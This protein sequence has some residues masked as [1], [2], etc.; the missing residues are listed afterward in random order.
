[1]SNSSEG[2]GVEGAIGGLILLIMILSAVAG[3]VIFLLELAI[4]IFLASIVALFFGGIVI[5]VLRKQRPLKQMGIFAPNSEVRQINFLEVFTDLNILPILLVPFAVFVF[6]FPVILDTSK[7]SVLTTVAASIIAG[8]GILITAYEIFIGREKGDRFTPSGAVVDPKT[9]R[10]LRP[11]DTEGVTETGESEE[12]IWEANVYSIYIPRNQQK[13]RQPVFT[14]EFIRQIV[15]VLGSCVF[16]I[17]ADGT[18]IV[19]QIVDLEEKQKPEYV[20]D[21]I[22]SLSP[23]TEVVHT[24]P[25]ISKQPTFYRAVCFFTQKEHYAFPITRLAEQGLVNPLTQVTQAMNTLRPGEKASYNVLVTGKAKHASRDVYKKFTQPMNMG[26]QILD[27]FGHGERRRKLYDIVLWRVNPESGEWEAEYKDVESEQ[28]DVLAE[29]WQR[30]LYQCLVWVEAESYARVR[31]ADIINHTKTPISQHARDGNNSLVPLGLNNISSVS[32]EVTTVSFDTATRGLG[33]YKRWITEPK[34]RNEWE[35]LRLIFDLGELT[36]LWHLPDNR[37]V[38]SRIAELD[39]RGEVPQLLAENQEGIVFGTG[40]YRGQVTPVYVTGE[41]R[42]T[43]VEILGRNGVGKSTFLHNL[44]HQDI[45]A[46]QGVT[47]IDPHGDLV[48]DILRYSIPSERENDLVVFDL[49]QDTPL[50]L[51]LFADPDARAAA[52]QIAE[53]IHKISSHAAGDRTAKFLNNGLRALSYLPGA[54]MRDFLEF[55]TEEDV[56]DKVLDLADAAGDFMVVK[57]WDTDYNRK[58]DA[59]Q[60][61]LRS[62]ILN[63]IEA[64]YGNQHLYPSLCHPHLIPFQD[65]MEQKKI[66][67]FALNA[68]P[69]KVAEQGISL[70]GKILVSLLQQAGMNPNRKRI[71]HYVYIDE[72]QRFSSPAF[73]RI[74][75]EARKYKLHFTVANQGLYQLEERVLKAITGNVGTFAIFRSNTDDARKLAPYM[76]AGFDVDALVN[77]DKFT[78]ALATSIRGNTQDAFLLSTLPSPGADRDPKEAAEKETNLRHLAAENHNPI[79]RQEAEAQLLERYPPR[80]RRRSATGGSIDTA[81]VEDELGADDFTE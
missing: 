12:E 44:I 74:F 38:S 10:F 19:W 28:W 41:A 7:G 70:V 60:D 32:H 48:R 65:Y 72:M 26:H 53:I 56:R 49:N 17:T 64:F 61:D 11:S 55:L 30:D 59:K 52:P 76:R 51:N 81:A 80:R 62:P 66:M 8:V 31:L 36:A 46:G 50:P 71:P 24:T 16:R 37:F 25:I 77:L 34:C 20:V 21:T 22:R 63:R 78:C 5:A 73:E 18:Q 57:M 9:P 75:S 47:V 14:E 42:D 2:D 1:M 69:R 13:P 3:T 43:H 58:S 40:K 54:T 23:N 45:A 4:K 29:K 35:R 15:A 79:T 6:F 39:K 68:D 33:T 67:L 27:W